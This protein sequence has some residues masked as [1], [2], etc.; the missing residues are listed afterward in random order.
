MKTDLHTDWT[1]EDICK[2]FIFDKNENKGFLDW[3]ESS[4]SSRNTKETIS[5]AMAKEMWPWW[6]PFSRDILWD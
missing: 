3:M 4:L 6:N 1:V 2:G 5:T